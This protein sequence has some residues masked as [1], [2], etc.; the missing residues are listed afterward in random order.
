MSSLESR[1]LE[2]EIPSKLWYQMEVISK[3]LM[4]AVL[5]HNTHERF[6]CNRRFPIATSLAVVFLR[7][8]EQA[9]PSRP[10]H[11]ISSKPWP[12]RTP[13]ARLTRRLCGFVTN[14]HEFCGLVLVVSQQERRTDPAAGHL[15]RRGEYS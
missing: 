11:T 7:P 10:Q 12:L 13:P 15:T 3:P 5:A 9:R 8:G 1:T 4:R 6:C 14:R 2:E